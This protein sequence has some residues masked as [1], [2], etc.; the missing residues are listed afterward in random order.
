MLKIFVFDL[1]LAWI[2]FLEKFPA[3]DVWL[4]F[5]SPFGS[6]RLVKVTDE[7]VCET[8]WCGNYMT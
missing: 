2:P 1:I 6:A 8:D 3:A 5:G 7:N 4:T